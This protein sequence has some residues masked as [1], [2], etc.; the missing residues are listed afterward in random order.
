MDVRLTV[1]KSEGLKYFQDNPPKIG[2][3]MMLVLA[4][5]VGAFVAAWT[6]G[7][8]TGMYLPSMWQERFG[9]HP[10]I[11]LWCRDHGGAHCC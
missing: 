11:D 7:E 8:L 10:C 2:W 3:E 4:V 5:I 6:G 1:V 9:S